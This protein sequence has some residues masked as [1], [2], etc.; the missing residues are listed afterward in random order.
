[1]CAY[2]QES[3]SINVC[4]CWKMNLNVC[5]RVCEP[6]R[7][8]DYDRKYIFEFVSLS[9]STIM[10]MSVSISLNGSFSLKINMYEYYCGNELQIDSY[11]SAKISVIMIASRSI[12]MSFSMSTCENVISSLIM[13]LSAESN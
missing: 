5:Q 6:E 8:R 11:E 10:N 3:V 2:E 4:V 7:K 9:K 12:G 13:S 1:M